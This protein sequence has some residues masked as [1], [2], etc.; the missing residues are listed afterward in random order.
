VTVD[1]GSFDEYQGRLGSRTYRASL[2]SREAELAS[3]WTSP[4]QRC[5]LQGGPEGEP[6]PRAA[7]SSGKT[8]GRGQRPPGSS[9]RPQNQ[10]AGSGSVDETQ[11]AIKEGI[12]SGSD[13]ASSAPVPHGAP[14]TRDETATAN[15]QDSNVN[16][17]DET[18]G[19]SQ[20]PSGPGPGSPGSG[21]VP[22][23]AQPEY[24]GDGDADDPRRTAHELVAQAQAL[25][26]IASQDPLLPLWWPRGVPD[27][28]QTFPELALKAGLAHAEIASGLHDND[29]VARVGNPLGRPK[30][31]LLRR[32]LVQ[33]Q[34]LVR[35]EAFGDAARWI[36]TAGGVASSALGSMSSSQASGQFKKPST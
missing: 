14:R 30:R 27:V 1:P 6:K 33:I 2:N 4:G 24:P 5:P 22:G 9:P 25:L 17:E 36:K 19:Q 10:T 16:D 11:P 18:G 31:H 29:L 32:L 15:E 23:A 26:H 20:P 12:H 28:G 7:S 21:Q 34:D 8:S 35:R 3:P 13:D